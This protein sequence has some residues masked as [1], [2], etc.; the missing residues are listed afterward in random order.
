MTILSGVFV[1]II[2]FIYFKGVLCYKKKNESGITI[3]LF[4]L[5]LL[6]LLLL[7]IF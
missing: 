6:L 7:F 1:I 3:F 5:L 4:L 2:Y